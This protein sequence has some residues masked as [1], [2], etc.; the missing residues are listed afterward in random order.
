MCGSKARA[1]REDLLR[2]VGSVGNERVD[3]ELVSV[4]CCNV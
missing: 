2:G 4:A 3:E 1:E